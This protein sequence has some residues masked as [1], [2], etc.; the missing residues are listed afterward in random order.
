VH[1]QRGLLNTEFFDY[2]IDSVIQSDNDLVYIISTIPGNHKIYVK[3]SNYAIVKTIEQVSDSARVN[4]NEFP[5]NDSLVVRRMVYFSATSEFQPY[6]GKTYLKYLNE[7]DAYEV[8]HKHTRKREFIV[9]SYK[10]FVVTNI[11]DSAAMPFGRKE[12]YNYKDA[13]VSK[14]YNA[15]FWNSFSTVQL[16]PLNPR[17][18]RDL[19]NELPLE[20][21]FATRPQDK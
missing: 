4:R 14:E 9:E 12:S 1:Y 15:A 5:L 10:E 13:L 19:E 8:L 16:S 2:E 17:V 21:Q 11:L 3:E 7:T 20:S 6:N 18:K